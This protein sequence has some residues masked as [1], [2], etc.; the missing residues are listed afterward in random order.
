M[1]N[2]TE[3]LPAVLHVINSLG[4]GGAER[5]LSQLVTS[6]ANLGQRVGV[7]ILSSPIGC[8]ADFTDRVSTV[9]TV[10]VSTHSLHDPRQ[11]FDVTHAV[12]AF[13]PNVVHTHLFPAQ[14]WSALASLLCD[15]AI[16]WV[17]T[18]HS[19]WNRR[20]EVV[21]LKPFEQWIYNHYDRV[22]SITDAVETALRTWVK[23]NESRLAVIP[24]G[25]DL[26]AF[27]SPERI[28]KSGQAGFTAI[29]LARLEPAKDLVTLLNAVAL[30]SI[31]LRLRIVGDGVDRAML[32]ALSMQLGI[33]QRV[34][35]LGIRSDVPALLQDADIY[36]QSSH[37]E[38]FSLAVLEGMAAGLPIVASD[39]PGLSELVRGHGLLF[40]QGDAGA[41]AVHLNRMMVEPE[42]RAHLSEK[43]LERAREFAIEGTAA[44]CLALYIEAAAFKGDR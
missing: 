1:K 11:I 37:W 14:L 23:L 27:Q 9:A 40:V 35:F 31:D 43:S 32:E 25:I 17:T 7:L 3:R 41:L 12:R 4:V 36:V 44:A 28:T 20:R 26:S 16:A 13:Q 39:V 21:L 30:A 24:N 8:F 6:Q 5:L 15:R 18:E 34:D 29:T 38:G 10:Y 2:M 19:T 22:I 42:S 33:A